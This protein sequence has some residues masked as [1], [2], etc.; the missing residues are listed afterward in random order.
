MA[1]RAK[2]IRARMVR[3][4]ACSLAAIALAGCA[5]DA[6]DQIASD[7]VQPSPAPARPIQTKFAANHAV[8]VFII[9]SR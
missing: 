5:G 9:P 2:S 8:A 3:L 6:T 7:E 1:H 4:A